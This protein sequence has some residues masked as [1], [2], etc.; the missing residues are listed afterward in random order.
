M[1]EIGGYFE[2]ELS[3]GC[4]MYSDLIMLNSARNALVYAIKAGRIRAIRMPY[5]NCHV[6]V[7]AIN[8]FCPETSIHYYHVDSSFIP[9]QEGVPSGIPLYYVNYYGLQTDVVQHMGKDHVILDNSQAFY[10]SPIPNGETIYCPRKFFGVS[11]GAY[12]STN[13]RLKDSLEEDT[14]W[15][16][17]IHLLKRIDCSASSAYEDFQAADASLSGRPLKLMSRLTRRILGGID[18]VTVRE[19]RLSNFNCLHEC[20]AKDNLLTVLIDKALSD[21]E[22]VPLCYPLYALNAEQIRTKLIS[23]KIYIPVYWPELR[24]SSLLTDNERKLVNN[25]VCL[26]IDQRY[27]EKEISKIIDILSGLIL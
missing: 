12:L 14:S 11:D 23:K 19:S 18:Y 3:S 27:D 10:S 2:L 4:E 9:I 13:V 20:F 7:D 5:Y 8:R 1:K 15:E 22:F 24:E 21:H 25:I 17:A 26:P 6:V 16:H